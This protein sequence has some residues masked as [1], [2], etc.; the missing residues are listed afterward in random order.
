MENIRVK[1]LLISKQVEDPTNFQKCIEIAKK[2]KINIIVLEGGNRINIERGIFFDVLW[3]DSKN[4]INENALN[5]NSIVCKFY[6]KKF[7]M[8][9]TGD[10]EEI[11][12]R[13]ILDQNIKHPE[14]LKSDI[15]KIAHHGSKTSSN[16]D[17]IEAVN[18]KVALIGVGKNNNFGHPSIDVINRLE[19]NGIKIYRTDKDGEISIKVNKNGDFKINKFKY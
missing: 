13:N 19:K 12:E 1:N 15:L 3:P 16:Q 11:A 7:S 6:Y 18:P 17:F 10:I 8:L 4:I 9:F 14:I 5:N 2:K